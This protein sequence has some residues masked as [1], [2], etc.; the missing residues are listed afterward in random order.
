L[1]EKI[2]LPASSAAAPS[3][4]SFLSPGDTWQAAAD[5]TRGEE[6]NRDAAEDDVT[7]DSF[8]TTAA[9]T[10]S[11]VVDFLNYDDILDGPEESL[12]TQPQGIFTQSPRPVFNPGPT[13]A[14]PKPSPLAFS[15]PSPPPLAFTSPSPPP[16]ILPAE[17]L[18]V[19]QVR[20]T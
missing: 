10:V 3:V 20:L 4:I 16:V 19:E 1:A 5:G 8:P 17:E 14:F 9:P 6:E 15:S 2:V 7:W 11:S 18:P 13:P 12:Q